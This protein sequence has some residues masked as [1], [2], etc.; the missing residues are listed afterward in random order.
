MVA[1]CIARQSDTVARAPGCLLKPFGWAAPVIAASLTRDPRLACDLV[2]L[3]TTRLHLI[4][5]CLTHRG[6]G[7]DPDTLR[8]IARR[9]IRR[10]LQD[11]VP[12]A[13][14]GV[15]RVLQ[16]LPP[17]VLAPDDYRAVV[18]L[19]SRRHAGAILRHACT[20]DNGLIGL[21]E[22]VPDPLC[23][24]AM[25]SVP[26]DMWYR[27]TRLRDSLQVIARR[28]GL[29]ADDII[30]DLACVAANP[31]ALIARLAALVECLPLPDTY[32]P[33][34]LGSGRR[35]DRPS[36]LRQLGRD[37][38]NCLA[39]YADP[40]QA[41]EVAFYF[42]TGDEGQSA[43]CKVD[44][45]GRLGWALSDIKGPKNSPVR[46][47]LQSKVYQAFANIDVQPA[48]VILPIETL[49]L[50]MDFACEN[51]QVVD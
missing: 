22:G 34:S 35:I 38:A 13:P 14:P 11:M 9:R 45:V 29:P 3:S 23:R 18:R 26:A 33:A 41:G 6:R 39:D 1:A 7:V 37:W 51:A 4:A 49:L 21:L 27:M 5:L 17:R 36:E 30:A 32:P 44:R 47:E 24:A 40:V 12:G 43:I 25:A 8:F 50:D 15:R 28:L 31:K 46:P 48:I 2:W 19:L 20:I 10:V 16:H 42:W